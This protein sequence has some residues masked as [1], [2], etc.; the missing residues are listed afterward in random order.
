MCSINLSSDA[1][2]ISVLYM[3]FFCG[4]VWKISV[5]FSFYGNISMPFIFIICSK[6][7]GS[8]Y[9]KCFLS[10][11]LD[12]SCIKV[13]DKVWTFFVAF[14]VYFRI[15]LSHCCFFFLLI[16]FNV[17][18]DKEMKSIGFFLFYFGCRS[19]EL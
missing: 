14:K 4:L 18:L 2:L 7:V 8:F 15:C 12:K 3:C 10:R 1:T 9:Y 17:L 19:L 16:S 6:M 11:D 5:F 13:L